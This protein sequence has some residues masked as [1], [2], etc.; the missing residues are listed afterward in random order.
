[1]K[2]FIYGADI[3]VMNDKYNY[4]IEILND[5]FAYQSPQKDITVFPNGKA[6][7]VCVKLSETCVKKAQYC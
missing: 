4:C 7:N 6:K 2:L 1:M 3:G 5:S